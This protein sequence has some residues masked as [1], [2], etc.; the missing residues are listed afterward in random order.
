MGLPRIQKGHDL[1]W[2]IV[3]RLTKSVHFLAVRKDFALERYAELY[4]P[5]IVR[6]HGV[7]A[8]IISYR[9]SKFTANFWKSLQTALE[10]KPQFS[11]T[12][13]LQTD[14][15]SKRTI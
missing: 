15:Q 1:I 13:H 4:V 12:Y 3:D 8:T 10:S 2:V 5:Q 14:G 6:L 11:T 7:P 9:D